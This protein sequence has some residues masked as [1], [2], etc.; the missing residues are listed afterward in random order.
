MRQYTQLAQ[1]VLRVGVET[2]DRTGVGTI[3]SFGHQMKFD[4]SARFPLLTTKRI[5]FKNIAAELLWF[6]SGSTNVGPLQE[7]GVYIWDAWCDDEGDLGPIYGKQWRDWGGSVDQIAL[8]VEEI[9]NNPASRRQVVSAWNPTDLPRM[10]LPPCHVLFQT[11][12]IENQLSLHVYQRSADVFLGLPYN[13][14]SYA[15][16]TYMLAK[17]TGLCPGTLIWSGGD[18]HIYTNHLKQIREQLTREPRPSP[19]LF[20]DRKPESIN[21]FTLRDFT[22]TNYNPHP[23]LHGEVAV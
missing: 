4:I 21:D 9:R 18:V 5:S 2:M 17:V 16:L 14:A 11:T 13:I 3:R 15:L 23:P 19:F 22:L 20:I 10:A 7:Q 12:V 1:E 6:L 8:L